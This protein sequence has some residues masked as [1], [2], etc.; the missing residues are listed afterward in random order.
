MPAIR[1]DAISNCRR[2]STGPASLEPNT[3]RAFSMRSSFSV[4][5]NDSDG[6]GVPDV[7]VGG[8]FSGDF[9]ISTCERRVSKDQHRQTGTMLITIIIVIDCRGGTLAITRR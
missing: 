7:R 5:G 4:L 9:I 6:G 8:A 3:T 1:V 2:R